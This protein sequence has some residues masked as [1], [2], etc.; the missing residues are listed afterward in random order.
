MTIGLEKF[1][2]KAHAFF[3]FLPLLS[4]LPFTL[5]T[6]IHKCSI[7]IVLTDFE[8]KDIDILILDNTI[9]LRA[10][11]NN[12]NRVCDFTVK[13][14]YLDVSATSATFTNGHL[15]ID[16]PFLPLAVPFQKRIPI[17]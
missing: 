3:S 2:D 6:D 12:K 13:R 10:T 1:S 16:I 9:T 5:S 7:K 11:N 15:F 8:K 17:Q 14:Q 4:Y